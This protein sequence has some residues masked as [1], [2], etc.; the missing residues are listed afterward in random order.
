MTQNRLVLIA[1]LWMLSATVSAYVTPHEKIVTTFVNFTGQGE[2]L[3][4]SFTNN[5]LSEELNTF[6]RDIKRKFNKLSAQ[7]N[8]SNYTAWEIGQ[9]DRY[10]VVE[11]VACIYFGEFF[12]KVF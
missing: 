8:C 9:S 4:S 2:V 11:N 6:E 10:A 5:D 7:Y 12:K 1:C 3:N